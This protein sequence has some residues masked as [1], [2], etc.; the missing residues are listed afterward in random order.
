MKTI[1]LD[2]PGALRLTE[3]EPPAQPGP[4]EALIRVQRVGICGSDLHAFMG[5]QTFFSYP[6]VLGHELGVEVVALG[7][8]VRDLGFAVGDHCCVIPYLN[9]GHCQ[10]C[11]QGKTNC[12]ERMQVLGVHCDGGMREWITVPVDKLIKSEVIPLDH[13]ALVEMLCIGAHAVRRAE[14]KPDEHVLVIGAGPIGLG[15]SLFAQLVGARVI[16]LEMSDPRLEFCRRHMAV[17]GVI[18][19]KG[20]ALSQL[21]ASLA[22][23]LPTTVFDATGSP[24][25][26]MKA[27]EYV[28]HGGKLVYVGHFPGDITFH[29]PDFHRREMTLLASRNATREDFVW[30]IKALETGQINLTPWI[31]HCVSPEEIVSEFSGWLDPQN[32]VV[33]AMLE[34]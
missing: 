23:E 6:R 5:N 1:I 4:A 17:E 11:R 22:G 32:G 31:T 2:K 24:K 16:M 28:A 21:R 29:D 15:V 12:C 20:D 19:G 18:D 8:A 27:F 34:F 3:T 33:K 14:L 9:C 26:M 25:S 13:L 30:V 10:A 7:Q